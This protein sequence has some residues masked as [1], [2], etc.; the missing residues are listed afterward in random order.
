[1]GV[2]QKILDA[3]ELLT[4]NSIQQAKYDKTIQAQVLSCED[5]ALGKYRCKFQ[6]AIFYAYG[7]PDSSYSK[8]TL[9]YILVPENDM[10][11]EK[12][13]L[14]TVQKLGINYIPTIVGEQAYSKIGTNCIT[15]NNTYYLATAYNYQYAIYNNNSNN[16]YVTINNTALSMYLQ[17]STS[18]IIAMTVKT[19]I[20]PN[21]QKQG[22]YGIKFGLKFASLDNDNSKDVIMQY[23]LDQNNMIDNPYNLIYGTRQYAIFDIDGSRF[24]DI[25]YIKIFDK[26]FPN[27]EGGY[28]PQG[29]GYTSPITLESGGDFARDIAAGKY[30]REIRR[31]QGKSPNGF[32]PLIPGNS[33][34]YNGQLKGGSHLT[35]GILGKKNGV[36]WEAENNEWLINGLSS[37]KYKDIMPKIQNGTFNPYSYAND[38]IKN[39]MGKH[40]NSLN[41]APVQNKANSANQPNSA[42]AINGKIKVD[43]PQTI[44]IKLED[45][46]NIG[47]LDTNAI[48]SMVALK[49][50]QEW[51]KMENLSGFN[52]EDFPYKNVIA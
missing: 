44:T 48:T 52:K 15:S 17:Q 22:H 26:D 28:P 39:D 30:D 50:M 51:K 8:G 10:Q 36:L 19:S 45:G 16:N 34:I 47:E 12:T 32:S 24:K 43:I 14:G 33:G 7:S 23:I 41:V 11:K 20:E 18:L 29:S 3:I 1:M 2:N 46:T 13:I 27:S 49:I 25:E 40:L 38:L 5:E 4:K 35:G 37:L 42:N 31:A 21:N 6:D 9:V